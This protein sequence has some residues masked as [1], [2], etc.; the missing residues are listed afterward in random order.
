MQRELVNNP[1][2]KKKQKGIEENFEFRVI[3]DIS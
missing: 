1:Q 3:K 2:P